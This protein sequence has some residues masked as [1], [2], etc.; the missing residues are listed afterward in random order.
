[1]WEDVHKVYRNII[2]FEISDWV[3]TDFDVCG[4]GVE[5]S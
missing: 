1:M 3:S 2:P 4:G 5:G